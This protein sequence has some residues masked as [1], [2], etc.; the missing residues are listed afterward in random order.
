MFM[1]ALFIITAN[2]E[3]LKYPSLDEWI[4]KVWYI[5]ILQQYKEI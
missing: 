5:P 4:N 2:W 1:A 3:Q